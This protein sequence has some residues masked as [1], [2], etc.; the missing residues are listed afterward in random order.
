[1]AEV[2]GSSARRNST[3]HVLLLLASV[4]FGCLFLMPKK[5]PKKKGLG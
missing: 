3:P 2:A 4:G 1:M 5:N